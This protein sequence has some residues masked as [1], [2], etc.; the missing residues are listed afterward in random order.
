M[1]ICG[2]GAAGL[3]AAL[4][5]KRKTHNNVSILI[6]EHKDKPGKKLLATG[7]GRC[8]FANDCIDEKSFR[9]EHPEFGYNVVEKFDKKAMFDLFYDEGVLTTSINGYYYP[10]SLQAQTVLNMFL[11]NDKNIDKCIHCNENVTDISKKG[12]SFRIKTDKGEYEAAYVVM[13]CGGKAFSV[14]GSD[15]SGYDLCKK[16]GHHITRLRPSL[17]G[18]KCNGL[19]FKTCQGVRAKGR[20]TLKSNNKKVISE[21]GEIQFAEYGLSGIP[22]F[23][24]S[25]YAS[26][27]LADKHKTEIVID[28]A[29]EY[30]YEQVEYIM[31]NLVHK[32]KKNLPEVL[33]AFVPVKLAMTILKKENINPD[34]AKADRNIIQTLAGNLKALNVN[35]IADMGFEKAQV[36]AGGVDTNDVKNDTL[37]S[38]IN[39]NFYI[40]GELLDVDG[41]CGGYNLHFAFASAF[42]AASDICRK[43]KSKNDN[44]SGQN[45]DRKYKNTKQTGKGIQR[46]NRSHY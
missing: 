21:Y 17:I 43:V 11:K 16:L 33:N 14:H 34:T 31:W 32:K 28:L 30:E 38:K 37:E 40:T 10:R 2:A 1:I 44:K 22:V 45:T 6:L 12:S 25:R 29:S 19:D 39:S 26:F 41:N 8:N 9:G 46:R 35:V 4:V 3:M 24:I 18:L 27:C 23:Q 20:L 15:G 7:N 5:L 36:T 13:A 42:L